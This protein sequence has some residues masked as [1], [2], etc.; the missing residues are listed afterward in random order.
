MEFLVSGHHFPDIVVCRSLLMP[1]FLIKVT[2][3]RLKKLALSRLRL[4]LS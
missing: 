1:E 4:G 2:V 3:A